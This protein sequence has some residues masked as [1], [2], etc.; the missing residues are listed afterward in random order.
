MC[1]TILKQIK[2]K[3]LRI[4]SSGS[5]RTSLMGIVNNLLVCKTSSSCRTE[6]HFYIKSLACSYCKVRINCSKDGSHF[7]YFKLLFLLWSHP[8]WGLLS[9]NMKKQE[10]ETHRMHAKAP[11]SNICVCHVFWES[12]WK[13][14]QAVF[15]VAH[16]SWPLITLLRLLVLPGPCGI[17][18]LLIVLVLNLIP[19]EQNPR[20]PWVDL[21]WLFPACPLRKQ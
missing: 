5:L 13:K 2:E 1:K 7:L 9:F 16:R 15:H 17:G 19:W 12:H 21:P 20:V 8:V 10:M 4:R 11:V 14:R 18:D 3:G 6:I